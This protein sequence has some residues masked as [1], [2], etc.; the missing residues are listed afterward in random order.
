[1]NVIELGA[2]GGLDKLALVQREIRKPGLGEVLIRNYA[3]SL[4]FHDYAVVTGH[5]PTAAGIVPMSDGAGEVIE[6]GEGVTDLD[7]DCAFSIGNKVISLFCSTWDDGG[8]TA[9]R[10]EAVPGDSMDGFAAEYVTVP[11]T[12]L[13]RAPIGYSHQEAA[14]LPCAALTAWRA[15]MVN[16]SLKMGDTV[17]V[18]GSGGVSIFALQ[19][20][21]AAG[22]TVIATSSSDEK[23]ETLKALGAD[24]LINYRTRPEWSSVV[25]EITAGV[26]VDHVIE[27]GGPTTLPQSL[28]ACRIGGH[29][30]MIGVL[31]GREGVV[32]TGL[33]LRKNIRL[34][35]LT[36][37]NRRQQLDMVRA[38]ESSGI[39]P[40]I[41]STFALAN[42]ADAFRYQESGKHFGK[43]TLDLS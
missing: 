41:D 24:H 38:L 11:A 5:L 4:N 39:R 12:A 1:M 9:S 23:L 42:I 18:Q 37:G 30:A 40:V 8:P 16:G 34:Q 7:S 32:P 14:T 28:M 21:K 15:L 17:L 2:G 10:L 25:L 19:F 13:T 20:A 35:G 31:T 27:V 6:I 43:I 26:G 3:S 33:L 29:I 36:V 22:A